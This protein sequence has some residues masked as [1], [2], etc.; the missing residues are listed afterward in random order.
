MP[1]YAELWDRYVT[2][3]FPQRHAG[4][5]GVTWPGDEW[6]TVEAWDQIFRAFFENAGVG[7]W[8]A[9]LEIGPGSGKYTAR[10]LDRGA[11]ARVVACDVSARFLEVCANRLSQHME[12]GRLTTLLI[13]GQRSDEL[14]REV[15]RLGLRRQL[16]AVY[17]ID[18]MV[19]VDLQYLI[20]YL[21][22]AALV[23]RPG[24]HLVLTLADASS[25]LGFQ[26]LLRRIPEQYHL[27]GNA[28]VKFEYVS[29]DAVAN[30]L[31]RLGFEIACL[32]HWA[33]GGPGLGRD[34]FVHARLADPSRAE[35]LEAA[36]APPAK[37]TPPAQGRVDPAPDPASGR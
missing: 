33:P 15:E 16:D 9:A 4:K 14:L 18:A 6:G 32:D 2:K 5:P 29:R 17:S 37:P 3:G 31:A 27:Q 8:K 28:H 24:G 34:L 30:L 22:T 13:P 21:I 1:S 26:H 10:V 19:H 11:A 7:D 12:S 36:L 25:D 20:V 35:P 23:L